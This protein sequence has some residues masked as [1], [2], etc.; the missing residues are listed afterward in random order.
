[1]KPFGPVLPGDVTWVDLPL[2]AGLL[3]VS[4][5]VKTQRR[6]ERRPIPRVGPVVRSSHWSRQY[7]DYWRHIQRAHGLGEEDLPTLRREYRERGYVLINRRDDL[8]TGRDGR[9]TP[10]GHQSRSRSH[11][12]GSGE[13]A[14]RGLLSELEVIKVVSKIASALEEADLLIY[15]RCLML[16][17]ENM[18][19][20]ERERF[21][22][23][24]SL[25]IHP[26]NYPQELFCMSG[27]RTSDLVG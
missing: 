4:L 20:L 27:N 8:D 3:K 1:M 26:W 5:G 16:T 14:V 17:Y 19:N 22:R 23:R 11:G 24:P 18:S 15:E 12:P 9:A 7:R 13:S 21:L 25:T 10:G 2:L 6:M